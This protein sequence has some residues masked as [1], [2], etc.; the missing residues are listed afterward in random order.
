[1]L[2]QLMQSFASTYT[3]TVALKVVVFL[4]DNPGATFILLALAVVM[5]RRLIAFLL[6][7]FAV[8]LAK[9]IVDTIA[10]ILLPPPVLQDFYEWLRHFLSL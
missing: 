2:T 10:G 6:C 8:A 5:S 7:A 3:V 4:C 9:I 1:M